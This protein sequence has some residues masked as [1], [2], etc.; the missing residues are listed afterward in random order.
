MKNFVTRILSLCFLLMLTACATTGNYDYTDFRQSKPKSILVLPPLNNSPDL[1]ATYSV[2]ATAT[3]PLAESGYY[4]FPVALVDQTFKENG[5][6]NPGEIHQTSLVKLRQIFGADAVLYITVEKYGAS[7]NI[8]SSEV[9]VTANAKLVDSNNGKILWQGS[10][11]AS[12]SEGGNSSGGL[13]SVLITA[14]INQVVANIGD[15]GYGVS[16]MTSDRLLS[17]K[18]GGILYGPRSPSYAKD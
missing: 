15:P 9:R 5:L 16:K 13:A 8:I 18:P 4:V 6:I 10:A 7:Y 11:T 3:M 14:I 12:N 2:L 17:A 1:R